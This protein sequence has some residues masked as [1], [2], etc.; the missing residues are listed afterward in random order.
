M[1]SNA[2]DDGSMGNCEDYS[3]NN[4]NMLILITPR[5]WWNWIILYSLLKFVYKDTNMETGQR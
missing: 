5:L 1:W 3:Y 4:R 2:D